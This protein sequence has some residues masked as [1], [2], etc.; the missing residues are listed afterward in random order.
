MFNSKP[1]IETNTMQCINKHHEN[2]KIK[3]HNHN[4]YPLLHYLVP[5]YLQ[6]MFT[7]SEN[8]TGYIGRNS[9]QFFITRMQ[10]IY[11]QKVCFIEERQPGIILI[12]LCT[13]PLVKNFYFKLSYKLLHNQMYVTNMTLEIVLSHA[14]N[15]GLNCRQHSIQ[16][17]TCTCMW[18]RK[19]LKQLL[20][21]FFYVPYY[22]QLN[23]VYCLILSETI[24]W[25]TSSDYTYVV[26]YVQGNTRGL[27][28]Y[29]V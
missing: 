3:T 28:R 9:H 25:L 7:F 22:H 18:T 21:G 10:T 27:C 14:C 11:G 13:Q 24:C 19:Q 17:Y 26:S 2:V 4:D 23:N 16:Q 8:L 20:P 5:T 12:R 6:D 15:E 1:I 29:I